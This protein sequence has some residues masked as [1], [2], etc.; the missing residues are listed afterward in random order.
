VFVRDFSVPR[1][2]EPSLKRLP[3]GLG[4]GYAAIER[5]LAC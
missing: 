4:V 1:F 3:V 2:R 5:G